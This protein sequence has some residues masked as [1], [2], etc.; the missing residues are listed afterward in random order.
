M[1]FIVSYVLP[2]KVT[3]PLEPPDRQTYVYGNGQTHVYG[4]RV[5]YRANI[6]TQQGNEGLFI[7]ISDQSTV[8]Q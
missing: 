5:Y 1:I 4:H 7:S 2:V 6:T 8:Y 3:G